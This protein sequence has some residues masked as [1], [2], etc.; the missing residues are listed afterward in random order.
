MSFIKK[1]NKYVVG[2]VVATGLT[3]LGFQNCSPKT[4]FTKLDADST[5]IVDFAL[6]APEGCPHIAIQN[7]ELSFSQEQLGISDE[8]LGY[9]V[10]E[11]TCRYTSFLVKVLAYGQ[12]ETHL[13]YRLK[14]QD[15]SLELISKNAEGQAQYIYE[16]GFSINEN[17]NFVFFI[18]QRIVDRSAIPIVPEFIYRRQ[19]VSGQID[20]VNTD[21]N[22]TVI[23]LAVSEEDFN[24]K[25][26][27]SK[28]A[29]IAL[30]KGVI[31]RGGVRL[32]K[33]NLESGE[34][35]TIYVADERTAVDLPPGVNSFS[36][37]YDGYTNV[38]TQTSVQSLLLL[39]KFVTDQNSFITSI[40]TGNGTSSYYDGTDEKV[41]GPTVISGD[42]AYAFFEGTYEGGRRVVEPSHH[43]I[44]KNILTGESFSAYVETNRS[45]SQPAKLQSVSND[46]R[47][48]CIISYNQAIPEAWI[49]DTQSTEKIQLLPQVNGQPDTSASVVGCAISAD[50]KKATIE[51]ETSRGQ[52]K[53]FH[54]PVQL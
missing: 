27:Q 2:V 49:L 24:Y 34:I 9:K 29:E 20:I 53:V 22:G 51:V 18:P 40:L 17:N 44:K 1:Q 10:G 36:L 19:L 25:T 43:I 21:A 13:A 6:A 52:A 30:F 32:I 33:K 48:V 50:A 45:A 15:N 14:H 46:G 35:S 11:I 41:H 42:G 47:Y 28:G 39:N 12:F 54:L 3:L 38:S 37:S 7:S 4:Q 16:Q 26:A 8:I 31:G 23:P 5:K